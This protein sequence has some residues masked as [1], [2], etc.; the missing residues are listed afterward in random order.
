MYAMKVEA[1][2]RSKQVIDR[3]L[4][5]NKLREILPVAVAICKQAF[6][7]KNPTAL[8]MGNNVYRIFD[9]GNPRGYARV[10]IGKV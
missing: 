7:M 1:P 4:S 8:H 5:S 2:Y 9:V 10:T 3:R 6:K